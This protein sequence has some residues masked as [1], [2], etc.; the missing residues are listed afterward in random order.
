MHIF[1]DPWFSLA[2]RIWLWIAVTTTKRRTR[3]DVARQIQLL[4]HVLDFRAEQ[5]DLLRRLG[6]EVVSL[7]HTDSEREPTVYRRFHNVGTSTND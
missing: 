4:S 6:T 7:E 3:H 5:E 2:Q 1:Q